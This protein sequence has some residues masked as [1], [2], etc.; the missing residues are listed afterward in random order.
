MFNLASES[1][2]QG[3]I[4]RR[5]IVKARKGIWLDLRGSAA[6]AQLAC[7]PTVDSFMESL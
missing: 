2:A 1:F 3:R 5:S 6:T 7:M 4:D